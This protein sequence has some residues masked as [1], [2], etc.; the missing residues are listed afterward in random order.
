MLPEEELCALCDCTFFGTDAFQAVEAARYC[1]FSGTTK[2]TLTI[3]EVETIVSDG[4]FPI[5][6]L[7]LAPIDGIHQP[8]AFVI[9][10]VTPFGVMALDPAKGE[11]LIPRDV[12]FRG[13]EDAP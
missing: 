8:H 6:Y 10:S 7:D 12:F 1:G 9:L 11:R 4:L 2:Q 3:D 13:V 5:V